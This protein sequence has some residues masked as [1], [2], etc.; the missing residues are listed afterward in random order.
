MRFVCLLS[1]AL[2][3]AVGC[4]P[5]VVDKG[6]YGNYCPKAPANETYCGMCATDSQCGYCP[7]SAQGTSTCPS[8]PCATK[9][10]SSAGGGPAGGSG[11]T[12]GGGGGGS[13]GGGGPTGK[14]GH[15][16]P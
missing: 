11:G 2:A 13:G 3:V 8:D 4:N 15:R 6:P 9:C 14:G 7:I 1:G 5:F 10:D 16:C 12:G